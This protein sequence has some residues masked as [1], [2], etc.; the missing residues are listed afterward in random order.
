M[1]TGKLFTLAF[2]D[3]RI[4][5]RWKGAET[6]ANLARRDPGIR[7]VVCTAFSDGCEEELRR[8]AG[9]ALVIVHEPFSLARMKP[10]AHENVRRE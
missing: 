2:V 3:M 1:R 5:P 4:L 6:I 10:L 8:V 9:E 7:F